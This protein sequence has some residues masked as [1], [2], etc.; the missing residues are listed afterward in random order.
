M[1]SFGKSLIR[2]SKYLISFTNSLMSSDNIYYG[3]YTY[4]NIWFR[5][6]VSLFISRSIITTSIII[7]IITIRIRAGNPEQ[8]VGRPLNFTLSSYTGMGFGFLCFIV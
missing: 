7:D 4:T 1:I 2:S 8:P 5:K 6:F 3:N